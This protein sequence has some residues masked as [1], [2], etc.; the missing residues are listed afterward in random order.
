LQTEDFNTIVNSIKLKSKFNPIQERKLQ[1][2]L[3]GNDDRN[4]QAVQ[5][6]IT[7]ELSGF[8]LFMKNLQPA[9]KRLLDKKL[10]FSSEN[11]KQR[12]LKEK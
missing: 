1:S 4:K 9:C 5:T 2:I 12:Y 7:E 6:D 8:S 10:H 11:E 3:Y